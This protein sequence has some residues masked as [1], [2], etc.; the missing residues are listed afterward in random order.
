MGAAV[1]RVGRF[2]GGKGAGSVVFC[3][4]RSRSIPLLATA[5]RSSNNHPPDHDPPLHKPP[6]R[7][8]GHRPITQRKM[9]D[10][11]C[12]PQTEALE[13]SLEAQSIQDDAPLQA[14][15]LKEA[16]E[17]RAHG[18]VMSV[19]NAADPARRAAARRVQASAAVLPPPPDAAVTKVRL[20]GWLGA[21]A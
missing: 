16:E 12:D 19:L 4:P 5:A 13:L 1:E 8:Q 11:C 20:G 18:R 17:L 21:Q 15:C 6:T 7:A 10:P 9:A 3:R 14:C 2:C